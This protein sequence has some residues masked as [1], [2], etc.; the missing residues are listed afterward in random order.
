MKANE[1]RIGN[2]V[3]RRGDLKQ[4]QGVLPDAVLLYVSPRVYG[5]V[6]KASRV[7]LKSINPIPLTEE[8]L[9]KFGFEQDSSGSC[10]EGWWRS[11]DIEKTR[12]KFG[13][14]L[15]EE[16]GV[17]EFHY[18]AGTFEQTI[19]VKHV[20]Q[21]QNLYFALTGEELTIKE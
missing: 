16:T 2:W 9:V 1:L 8:W 10:K 12:D 5:G 11:F 3:S 20:H 7:V 15:I 6:N 17:M 14:T 21:L 19:T 13:V 4:V 18:D